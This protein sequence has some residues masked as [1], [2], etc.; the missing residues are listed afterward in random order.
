MRKLGLFLSLIVLVVLAACNQS[1][2]TN[3]VDKSLKTVNENGGAK[4]QP[5]ELRIEKNKDGVWKVINTTMP[6]QPPT[7]KRNGKINWVSDETDLYIQFPG[8]ILDPEGPEDSLKYGYIKHQKKGKTLKLHVKGNVKS[9][10]YFYAIFCMA[11][12][13]FAQEDSPPKIIVED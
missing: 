12:S 13:T 11:D 10:T 8:S 5:I 3:T 4:S 6:G 7:V 1:N 2:K 9:D